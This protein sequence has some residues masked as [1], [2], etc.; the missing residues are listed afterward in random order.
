MKGITRRG[1][2][3][4]RHTGEMNVSWRELESQTPFNDLPQLHRA[5]LAWRGV[6][7]AGTMPLRRAQQRVE[8]ELNKMALAGDIQKESGQFLLPA[9]VITEFWSLLD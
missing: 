9:A 3:Y 1:R 7:N 4:S 2:R 5:F 8:A 6:E